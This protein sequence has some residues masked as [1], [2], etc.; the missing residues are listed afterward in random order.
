MKALEWTTI[1][2]TAWPRGDWDNEPDKAQWIDEATGLPCLVN[3]TESG[4]L[5]GYVGVSASHPLHGK[6]YNDADVEVHGGLT[7]ADFCQPHKTPDRGICHL[8]ED[9]EDDK[10]WW[11]GFDCAHSG[12]ISPKY[13]EER[14]FI[15]PYNRYRT[16]GYAKR[17]C[18]ELARQLK[19]VAK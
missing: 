6:D 2:K 1:D 7:F 18:A 14:D 3:R 13:A 8:V 9:G 4:H 19:A 11:L 17:E 15:A 10:V 12:D 16:F 5:C